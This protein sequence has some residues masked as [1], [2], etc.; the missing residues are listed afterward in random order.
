[1]KQIIAIILIL[2]IGSIATAAD[3]LCMSERQVYSEDSFLL[4]LDHTEADSVLVEI[5]FAHAFYFSDANG[6]EV[7]VLYLEDPMRFEGNAEESAKIFFE[8]LIIFILDLF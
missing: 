6:K 4:Y 7:G 3:P 1:M 8:Y 2:G 5:S